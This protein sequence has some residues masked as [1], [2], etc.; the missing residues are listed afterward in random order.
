MSEQ[1]TPEENAE[2]TAEESEEA[3]T[4]NVRALGIEPLSTP[5]PVIAKMYRK[6]VANVRKYNDARKGEKADPTDPT[7][8]TSARLKEAVASKDANIS[9]T[10]QNVTGM[11]NGLAETFFSNLEKDNTLLTSFVAVTTLK[12][13]L[14]DAEMNHDYYF[15][16]A[17]QAEKD[18][19]GITV[20]PAEEVVQDKLT[21]IALQNLLQNRINIAQA[22]GDELPEDLFKVSDSGRT[23]F[24]TD[25]IPRLPK[26]D[27][28]DN[29]PKK[30]VA[31]VR[32][33]FTWLPVGHPVDQPSVSVD[34]SYTL[35]DVAHNI[36]SSGAYRISGTRIAEMLKKAGH[37]IGATKEP[38]VLEFPTGH[39]SGR[40]V[41]AE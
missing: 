28:G 7:V 30:N 33:A 12:S 23:S 1:V 39:L 25:I 34:P 35:N 41:P 31:N 16:R 5:I 19:Q 32:L 9:A 2:V 27:M 38:W 20:T 8:V 37:G 22:M 10:V 29:A 18:K 24:N 11:V 6:F 14:A 17:V 26:L 40:A 3:K 4:I 13:L 21:A 36:V 15:N